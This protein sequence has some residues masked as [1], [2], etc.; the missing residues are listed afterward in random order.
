MIKFIIK[1]ISNPIWFAF[2]LLSVSIIVVIFASRLLY[3]H[4]VNLLTD[5]LRERILTISITEAANIDTHDLDA[6]L[7]EDDWKKPEW[8]NVVNKLHKAKYTN[9]NIVFMYI[10]RYTKDEKDDPMKMEFVADADSIDP[11]ANTSGDPS[12]YVDVNRDGKVEPDGPDKLQWPGQPNPDTDE[13]PEAHEAYNGPLTNKDFYTDEYGTVLSGYAPIKDENGNTVA[14]LATDIKADDFSTITRQTLQPFI[15]F[16]AFLTL[17]ITILV[18][19]IISTWKK[20]TKS[21]EKINDQLQIANE[22]QT[23]LIHFISHQVK[24]FLAK[25]RDVFSLFLEEE[26]GPLPEYLKIPTK[27]G[28]DSGTKG[29]ATVQEILNAA[30]FKK[31]TV[32]YK[33]EPFDLKKVLLPIAEEQK[34]IAEGKGLS[35]ENHISDKENFE[36]K[37][38]AEQIGHALKNLIDNSIKYTV[39]GGIDVIL[40]K[41]SEKILFSVKD[42]GVGIDPADRAQLFTEGIRGKNSLKVNVESTGYGLFIVKKIVEAHHGRVWVES[43]GIGKGSVFYIEL[44]VK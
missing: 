7:V 41:T 40:S 15:I 22:Q 42:T 30:N 23:T 35:F 31:G 14:V 5:N 29:V 34:K 18:I 2:L 27:E 6:L 26:Y 44:P 8:A 37:G 21:L 28:L 24:G 38:D 1:K 9:K 43:Q 36:I 20:Y 11:Y 16:I 32:E 12:R 4:T 10:F 13:I 3:T 19:I 39:S 25:S 33:T 17:I